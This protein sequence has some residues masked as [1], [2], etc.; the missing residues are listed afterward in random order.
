M[1]ERRV[2]ILVEGQVVDGGSHIHHKLLAFLHRSQLCVAQ[3]QA[4]A[5]DKQARWEID[6]EIDFPV[7]PKKSSCLNFNQ[8]REQSTLDQQEHA[9]MPT[10]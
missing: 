8:Q 3:T 2:F 10:F 9:F 4:H 7:S 6:L 1:C 5:K